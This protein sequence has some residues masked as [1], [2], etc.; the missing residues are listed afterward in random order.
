MLDLRKKIFV[1]ASIVIAL[2]IATILGVMFFSS[3]DVIEEKKDTSEPS[4]IPQK[5]SDNKA[6]NLEETAEQ[7]F[8]QP[9]T[10]D[11]EELFARQSARLFA[12][13]FLSYSN[14]NG[15][16][17]IDDVMPLVTTRMKRWIQTQE[18]EN[19]NKYEGV[20]T[21]VIT[22]SIENISSGSAK[23]SIEMQQVLQTIDGVRTKN[24]SGSVN[25]IRSGD[26]WLIDGLFLDD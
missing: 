15:N 3:S 1:I 23:V 16:A 26:N 13:R 12:E 11:Q 18:I 5:V 4:Q 24:K 17:H 10:E 25:M 21:R 8:I 7:V 20:T 22:S 14:Q 2:F 6:I 19:G 9:P